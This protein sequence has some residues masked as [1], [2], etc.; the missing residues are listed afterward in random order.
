[1]GSK[2]IS[3]ENVSELALDVAL[4]AFSTGWAMAPHPTN[5]VVESA[6]KVRKDM[7]S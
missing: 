6:F 1:M 4:K 5:R 3:A 2:T 7:I